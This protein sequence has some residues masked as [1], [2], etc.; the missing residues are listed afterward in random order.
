LFKVRSLAR[1]LALALSLVA[2]VVAQAALTATPLT[3]N[4]IG[5]DSNRPASG[6]QYFPVGARVC[7]TANTSNVSVTFNWDSANTYI[8]L[9][10]G[11]QGTVTLASIA[12]GTC[13]DAYFEVQVTQ[14]A[15]AFDT[16]RRYHIMA[17][18]GSGSASTPTPRELYVEYLISQSRNAVTNMK[19]DGVAIAPGGGMNLVVGNTYAIELEGGTATQGYNQFEAFINFPNTIFQI[20]SVSTTYS[21]DNSP[22]VSNPSDKLY[23]DACLWQND[24]ASPNYRSC[25][26]GDFKVGGQ[27]V[28]TTYTVKIVGGG[29]TVQPLYA[30]LYD[31][32]GSSYHYNGDFLGSARIANIVDPTNVGFAK[33]FA[34]ASTVAGGTSTLTFTLTNT[35]GATIG[36]ANFADSLPT[37]SG[38]PMTVASPATY[39]TSGCGMPTFAPVAAA[40]SL[41]FANGT[42]APNSSCVVSVQVSLPATPTSGTFVNTSNNLFIGTLDTGRNATANLAVAAT[43]AGTGVCNLTMAQWNFGTYVT[44]PPLP[45][46]QAGNVGTA[47]ITSGNGIT[48]QVDT[49]ASGGNPA[50]GMLTYG[51][52]NSTAIN[53]AT[54]PYVQFAIDTSNY[55]A[56]K[57]QFDAQRKANGPGNDALYYSTDGAN[58]TLKSAFASTTTWTTYG[59]PYDFT[60]QTSTTGITYFRVYGNGANTPNQGADLSF[61]NVTFTGCAT[62]VGP[63]LTKAFT[64]NPIAVG[65]TS[66]LTF[67]LTNSNSVALSGVKFTDA[68]PSGLQVAGTPAAGTTC[69]GS[70]TWAPAP[71]ATTLAFG[72]TAGATV[73]AKVGAVNGSCTVTVNVTA[74][75][76]G[77][78]TNV[79]GFVSSTEGGT[80][81]GASGSAVA[82]LTA[83]LPPTIA[84]A[85]APDPILVGGTSLLTITLGNPNPN[86]ALAGVAFADTYP[87]G[88]VNV[89]PLSPAV[90]N[91]CGGT[92]TASAGGGGIALAGGSLAAGGTCT[93]TVTVTAPAAGSYAN[94]TGAVSANVAGTG[95]I[96][97]DML[98]V[99]APQPA[100]SVLKEVATSASGPWFKFLAVTPGT[101][102]YYRFT[103]ENTGDVTLNPF[104][105]ADPTLAG[106][107]ADPAT[108]AWQTANVP[109]TLPALPVATALIDPTATCVTGPVTAV[110]GAHTNSATA[111]GTYNSVSYAS[112][113]STADYVAA[114]PGFS[115]TKQ[116]ATSA[117]GPWSANATVAAGAPVYY[118]FTIV[119]TGAFALDGV[120]VTDPLVSTA[121]C[122]FSDPLA[123]GAATICVVGPVTSAGAAGTVVIN[124]ASAFGNN[125]G[126]PH[127]TPSA[128]A[129][130]TIDDASADVSMVKTLTT[131]GPFI[132]GQSITYTLVVANAGPNTAT[133]VQVTD[134]PTNLTI[135]S[136][137]GGGCAALPCTIA[138]LAMGASATITVTASINAAGA[139]DNSA[140]ANATQPDPNPGNNTDNTGNGGTAA[141]AADVSIAKTDGVTTVQAGSNTAYTITLSNAGPDAAASATMTDPLPSGMTFVSLS[142]PGGWSCT[143]PAV[144][145]GGT[146]SCSIASLSAGASAVFTLTA[147][148]GA[149]VPAGT[150][151][152]NTATASSSTADPNA[153]NNNATDTDQ[154]TAVPVPQADLAITKTDNVATVTAGGTTSY[155][156]VVSN[157]GPDA[158]SNASFSDALPANTTFVSLSAA[159]GWSCTTPAVGTS[160]TVTCSTATLTA[161]A[162]ASFT[163]VVAIGAGTPGGT[164]IANT[165]TVSA[166]TADPNSA[167]N[168]A[169]DTDTVVSSAAL[170]VTKTDNSANYTPGGTGT[171]VVVVTNGG[172]SAASSVT[173]SDTL[174]PGVTLAG[175]VTCVATGTAN[176]GTVTGAA[177]Q[178]SFGTTGAAIAAGAGHSLTFTVPV[179]Y[180]SAMTTNPLVNTATAT[181]PASPNASGSDSSARLASV[182]LV[183][184]KTDGSGTY[185]PGGTATYVVTV[186]NT[187]PT[188]A[189]NVTVTD[190]LPAGLT[191]TAAVTC[192]GNGAATC[193][194]VTGS[195]GQTSFG[196]TG[197]TLGAGA[198]D[199]LVFTV[200]VAFAAG[201]TSNPLVN[202]ATAADAATGATANG[203]DSNTLAAQVSLSVVKTDG[204]ATYTPGGTATYTVTVTN[205]G[206]ST[207]NSVTIADALPAGVTLTATV[208][209]V[210]NGASNCGTVSG[211]SGQTSFGAV[212]AVIVPGAG[213]T[214]VFTVPVAFAAGMSTDPLVN[215]ATA[216]DGPSGATGS[217]SDSNARGAQVT[218]AVAKTDNSAT[219]TPG[220]TGTYVVTVRNTGA[221]DALNVTV[222]DAL[223]IGVTLTAT[224]TCAA[225]GIATCGTVTGTAGQTSFGTTG[226][227]IGA[228]AGNTLVFTVPVAF[229]ANLTDDPL[230]NTATATDLASGATGSG[231]DSNT[232]S[233]QVSLAV[234]KTDGSA[235]YTP[236][237]AAVYAI[238]VLNA[239]VSDALNVTIA[240]A[241]PA[242]V[243]LNGTAT[244]TV[245]GNASC[246]TVTG[247]AGQ[248]SFGATGALIGSGGTNL[249]TF[250]VPVSFAANL[251]TNP[252]V[253]TVTVT[254]LASG[255]SGSA[256]D[257]NTRL[258][259]GAALTKTIL[260]GTI[261]SGGAATL[262]LVLGNAN[263][264]AL[265][266]TAA[267]TDAMPA[268]VTTTSGNSGT[269]SG[270]TVGSTLV[271]MAAGATIPP[272]GCTIVVTITSTTPGTV[273]N[274]TG[275]LQT[276]AGTTPP[277]SAPL[278]V[279]S[280]VA[281]TADLAI[282]KTNS[283][284]SVTPGNVVTYTMVVT[285]NGPS[286]VLGATVTD[287]VPS[288][289]TGVTWMCAASTGS[290]CP[291][292]GTGSIN[293]AVN[294]LAG[295][296]ATFT[297]T[298]T[299]SASATGTLTN[300]ATVTP[301]PGT[302][303]PV[304][305]NDA[306]TDADPIAMPFVD[307][308]I[309]KQNVGTFTPGQ[310][311]AQYVITVTNVG[312]VPSSG[313]VT[314]TDVLP[315]GL[316]ATAISGT[317]WTCTQTAGPCTRSDPLAPGASYPVIT[318]TVSVDPNPPTTLVNVVTVGGGGDVNGANNAA[319][320][321]VSFA[322]F[323]PGPEPIPAGSPAALALLAALLALFSGRQVAAR[324]RD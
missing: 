164:L 229:A 269:C 83:V 95:N 55:T 284:S 230:V 280:P 160:G 47:A 34:P 316:T 278:T 76:A 38:N 128:S 59:A 324:R 202:T 156:I 31:F 35:T 288:T 186:T 150:S 237:G 141:A 3:W 108:C 291:A 306:A 204:S 153:G 66:T 178:G 65:G 318:L 221:S 137:T 208:T 282:T 264:A 73:P 158:A 182:A 21:A 262:T 8:N 4:V 165:A 209:C 251:T 238:A 320:N 87:T 45:S 310:V 116:I 319:Q 240:D 29:G 49:A 117:A 170:A 27:D 293:A 245:T 244:C 5:L 281:P 46:T 213:N 30:L 135:T 243:T 148:V 216:T 263:A 307:L 289:L 96:A 88:L 279:T 151:L 214:L 272:G 223:P 122:T 86:D 168:S 112:A 138:S 140:S 211:T 26:G 33:A 287:I 190:A 50:P 43:P 113:P 283:V 48:H 78:H 222:N 103:V 259:S 100:I 20:L 312:A 179:A 309:A 69:A 197:A 203:S 102:L 254:D 2:P 296:T 139:F 225:N 53:T 206:L 144:G 1:I 25:V 67:T 7:S 212:A 111:S 12:A 233:A 180:A 260:P 194:T 101:N 92:L 239:G 242:G 265:T 40:T 54:S 274:V 195:D 261:A 207:A 315:A 302:V 227:G 28:R 189:A 220:G 89:S 271:T 143:T 285:N 6:P 74:T 60:G 123:V 129:S 110:L 273:T 163:L 136:V 132:N 10:P 246:G 105:V 56:V 149:G 258:M 183:V 196:A 305:G 71:G 39:S 52:L 205:G 42:I 75:T 199:S 24:P 126:N 266:L 198:G 104:G 235:T 249:L 253:N 124:I 317:G 308:A 142:A 192:T 119:N 15:A 290:S 44:N 98:N 157:A 184:T 321:V 146:V 247:T 176:C 297:L 79:S 252:L 276:D 300:T 121:N 173:V 72:Q 210:A 133:S 286:A 234:T 187:G 51:W 131:T 311:G 120:G 63:T 159:G 118:K 175:T 257:S 236:G 22:Y 85:F 64:P 161:S 91:S 90:T 292:S 109:S 145:T 125:G 61:D 11:S 19:L 267:F 114:P 152:A 255:A 322:P 270:V 191:L 224:V 36:G 16:R 81:S 57:L 323:W 94:L 215:T 268:G 130:Y 277:A 171:Y 177:G 97:G 99:D 134:T 232:R 200:P 298:G 295:G 193:G 303:D 18:D 218:L 155:T 9:R 70:P 201:M 304:P 167:N 217:G 58:W 313:L 84:K 41:S 241:L 80:N 174:P 154:V 299:L 166:A 314:V 231:F 256:S 115:L 32:S 23:A 82:S 226:A 169:T 14:T 68:L 294:L 228:G 181:D 127:T 275:S 188:D 106:T 93:V 77:P 147:N 219:Y 17:T 13:Q 248:T 62:P 301:P 250:L 185:T 37:L 162:N 172:P 107:G